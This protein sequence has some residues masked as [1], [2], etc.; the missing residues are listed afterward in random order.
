[1]QAVFDHLTA[2]VISIVIFGVLVAM[3]VRVQESQIDATRHYA[4]R[5]HLVSFIDFLE[6][7]LPNIGAGV[8]PADPMILDY[9]WSGSNKFI[10][11]Q[12]IVDTAA[13]APVE[14][15]K[16]ELVPT[17]TVDVGIDGTIDMVQCYELRR[18]VYDPIAMLY[19]LD[20][21]SQELLTDF[22]IELLDASGSPIGADL[23]DTRMIQ[24]RIGALSPLGPDQIIQ[25]TRWQTLFL[26]INLR[27]KDS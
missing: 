6:R 19:E 13:T 27:L 22:E 17:Q 23:N 9:S 12:A 7:D 1:M 14:Q 15:I 4:N 2:I 3:Q 5:T 10:E 25:R 24:V 21:K 8:D 11:F 18:F 16:Y 20:G 26:P